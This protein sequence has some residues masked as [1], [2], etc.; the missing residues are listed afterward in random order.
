MIFTA[1]SSN[2]KHKEGTALKVH[3]FSERRNGTERARAIKSLE[4]LKDYHKIKQSISYVVGENEF[5]ENN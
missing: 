1:F 3:H 2:T 4:V 5:F